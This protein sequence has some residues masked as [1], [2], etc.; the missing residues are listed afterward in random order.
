MSPMTSADSL[1]H[2]TRDEQW[3]ADPLMIAVACVREW[4]LWAP[5]WRTHGELEILWE[6]EAFDQSYYCS[7]RDLSVQGTSVR[8]AKTIR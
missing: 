3:A 8:P 5:D 1:E 2:H 6:R 7:I 4:T